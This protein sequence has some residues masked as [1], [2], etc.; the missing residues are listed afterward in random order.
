MTPGMTIIN[1]REGHKDLVK[2]VRIRRSGKEVQRRKHLRCPS[3]CTRPIVR[4]A[5]VMLGHA[6][7]RSSPSN[8][9]QAILFPPHAGVFRPPETPL[10]S[11]G[12][13]VH[14]LLIPRN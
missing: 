5:S 7:R 6:I 3:R 9:L 13:I 2:P 1:H 12:S 8:A 14:A 10:R 4:I 11:L